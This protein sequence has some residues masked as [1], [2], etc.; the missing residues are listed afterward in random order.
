MQFNNKKIT[1][2]GAFAVFKNSI[3]GFSDDNVTNLSGSLAYATIFSLAPFFVV[4]LAVVGWFLGREAVEGEVFETLRQYLGA[5]A[6]SFLENIIANAAV[7]GKS[8]IA[9]IIG[10]GTLIFGATTVFAQIQQSINTIWGIKPKPKKGWL[11]MILNRLLSFSMIISLGFLL[12][13]FFGVNA[14]IDGFSER[15][16]IW[17]PD[18]TVVIIYIVNILLSFVVISIIFAA[19]FKFLP[20]AKIKWRDVAVGAMT[21][22]LLFMIGR[23]LISIYINNSNIDSTFGAAAS[24]VVM[25]VWIYYS[26]LILY[27]GAEF[28]KSWATEYGSHIYPTEY[29][30]IT[31][32]IEVE[33]EEKAVEAVNKTTVDDKEVKEGTE[34]LNEKVK[35]DFSEKPEDSY[36]TDDKDVI[37]M[38]G[39][40]TVS[41]QDRIKDLDKQ[42]E[43]EKKNLKDSGDKV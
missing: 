36:D 27:F 43:E 14:L 12:L 22:S 4:L 24:F 7:S 15:L 10:V 30:V 26:S 28:T 1:W 41:L 2:K 6:A 32:I 23:F 13:V 31:K 8:K 3:T 25:L 37:Y 40:N 33:N 18:I 16:Q 19:V 35:E 29:A 34:N 38:P 20:D 39:K 17:Y 5:N 42:I 9:A 21:T 11:K